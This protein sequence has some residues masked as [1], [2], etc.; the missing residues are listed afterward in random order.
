M[1]M[2]K[3]KREYFSSITLILGITATGITFSIKA[4]ATKIIQD[5]SVYQNEMITDSPEDME[6][7]KTS[8]TA[9]NVSSL[10]LALQNKNIQVEKITP[11]FILVKDNTLKYMLIEQSDDFV[12][13]EQWNEYE[14]AN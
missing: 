7:G 2:K 13:N 3:C 12:E 14:K 9:Q 6:E 11:D 5:Y 4:E 10:E 8:N 1:S